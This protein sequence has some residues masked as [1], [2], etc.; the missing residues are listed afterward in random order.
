MIANADG[1]NLVVRVSNCQNISVDHHPSSPGT[2]AHIGIMLVSPDATA[3]DP[4]TSINNYTLTYS[5][6][7]PSVVSS[8]RKRGVPAA[9]DTDLT[10]EFSPPTGTSELYV[11]ITPPEKHAPNWF[12]EGTVTTPQIPS[13]FLAN[14]W[15]LSKP[16]EVKM[17]TTIPLINFDFT[18]N[19][20]FHTSRN[21]VIG[22]LLGGT[23]IDHFPLS[24]R[25]QFKHAEMIVT[26]RP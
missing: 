16:G 21:N 9:L 25:G 2:V 17:A 19:V 23:R 18:S 14:W 22:K 5:S 3:T 13:P 15:Y 26:L 7:L 4:N 1:A 10:Y 11:A 8:L 20:R 12:L 6:N 24:F